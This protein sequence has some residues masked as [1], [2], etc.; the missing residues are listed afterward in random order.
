MDTPRRNMLLYVGVAAIVVVSIGYLLFNGIGTT[1]SS[2]NQTVSQQELSQLSNVANNQTLAGRIGISA[3]V[4]VNS[5]AYF[6]NINESVLTFN[7]KPEL[8]YIGAEFCPYCAASRW[9]IVLTLMRFGNM[10]GLRY[11]ESSPTDVFPN[12]PTFSFYPN[13]SYTSDYLSFR[14]FETETRTSQPL[15]KLD[16]ESQAIYYKYGTAIPFFDFMNRS[17]AEGSIENPGVYRGLSW[18]QITTQLS[19][20]SSQISQDVI[21][22]ANIYT[23]EVC[24]NINNTAPVCSEA[25]IKSIEGRFLA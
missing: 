4:G 18:Q 14:A 22:A 12:T 3:Y 21:G 24:K 15:Q 2:Y 8:L 20:P 10:T 23:A 1:S 16:N 5:S 11:S 25:Y 7:G 9:P 13:Y 6:K 19:D 17:V